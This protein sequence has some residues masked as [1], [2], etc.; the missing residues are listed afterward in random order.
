MHGPRR[1]TGGGPRRAG[2][3]YHLPGEGKI[4]CRFTTSACCW[5]RSPWS[6]VRPPR[7]A[8]TASPAS[9]R[10]L[11]WGVVTP[12]SKDGFMALVR[13][14]TV[15]R[16]TG[17]FGMESSRHDG[18]T[19]SM[20]DGTS[21]GMRRCW[22]YSVE[23]SAGPTDLRTATSGVVSNAAPE[24]LPKPHALVSVHFG[25]EAASFRSGHPELGSGSIGDMAVSSKKLGTEFVVYDDV[26]FY[27]H[28]RLALAWDL[29]TLLFSPRP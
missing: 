15:E 9:I 22:I 24:L 13:L 7:S 10:L 14:D 25:E 2:G 20:S 17:L 28:L 27:V 6:S 3:R 19:I 26:E 29:F 8:P 5:R 23:F 21:S 1:R 11:V 18:A 12:M 4:R 16:E